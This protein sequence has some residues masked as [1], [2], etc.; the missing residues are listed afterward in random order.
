LRWWIWRCGTRRSKSSSVPCFGIGEA[1][2]RRL[3]LTP[4]PNHRRR[5]P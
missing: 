5:T 4:H 2:R 3:A 1:A